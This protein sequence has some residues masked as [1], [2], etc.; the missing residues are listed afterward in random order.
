MTEGQTIDREQFL[1]DN[2][3]GDV[4]DIFTKRDITIE[5]LLEFDKD[6]LKQFAKEIGLDALSQNRLVKS[7][8]KLKPSQSSSSIPIGG[9]TG[10]Y[11]P[12][13]TQQQ[14]KRG[15]GQ[16]QQQQQQQHVIV[17]PEEHDAISKLYQRYEDS[18]KLILSLKNSFSLLEKSSKQC[19]I[20]VN[21]GFDKLIENLEN[22]KIELIEECKNIKNIKKDKLMKQ[23]EDLKTY[24]NKITN[25]KKKYEEL[26]SDQKLD[27][28][29]RKTLILTMIDNILNDKNITL[30]M[31]TQPKIAFNVNNKQINKFLNNLIIDDC[32]QPFPP[33]II[34]QKIQYDYCQ[35]I[36]KLD[37]KYQ[38]NN[39]KK[40][41]SFEI[42][43]CKL[44]KS[45][46]KNISK[47]DNKNNKKKKKK[48]KKKNKKKKRKKRKK[49]MIHHLQIMMSH[50]MMIIIIII[51]IMMMMM[52]M[53]IKILLNQM[54]V[55]K[56][57]QVQHHLERKKNQWQ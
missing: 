4:I 6:D 20:D 2:K 52:M 53:K 15:S 31:I 43:W 36:W 48:K 57:L 23:L 49:K 55:I 28:H 11:K 50:K 21:Q 38:T 32:D 8:L 44:P 41:L 33:I 56:I 37:K 35:I 27:I 45:Y 1:K 19:K 25:G 40:I 10:S 42:S 26:I 17:S 39:T 3:L 30:V 13:S 54:K 34:I 7:I 9:G 18:T 24:C 12:L 5:E 46:L 29:K 51:I 22:K 14:K 16:Q 47:D